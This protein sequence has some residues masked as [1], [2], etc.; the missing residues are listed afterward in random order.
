MSDSF[1]SQFAKDETSIGMK[2]LTKI[3]IDT[4]NSDP[5]SQKSYPIA[6]KHYD[7]VKDEIKKLIDAKVIYSSHSSWSGPIIVG[8]KGDGGKC[9]VIDYRALNKVT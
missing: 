8:P 9:L 7:W 5:I 2:N 1:K 6:I 3:K 4:G